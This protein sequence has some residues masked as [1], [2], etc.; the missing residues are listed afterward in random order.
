LAKTD[1]AAKSSEL[2]VWDSVTK[3]ISSTASKF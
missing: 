3:E 1:Y 2:I